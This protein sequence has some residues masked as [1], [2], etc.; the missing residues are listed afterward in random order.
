RRVTIVTCPALRPL[1]LRLFL[2]SRH[3]AASRRTPISGRSGCGRAAVARPARSDTPPSGP[4]LSWRHLLM[5][6]LVLLVV[7]ALAPSQASFGLAR[8]QAPSATPAGDFIQTTVTIRG[9]LRMTYS[10]PGPAFHITV[11]GKTYHLRLEDR[12]M[13][14]QA[15]QLDGETVVVTGTL[16]EQVVHVTTLVAVLP[17]YVHLTRVV[18]IK[19]RLVENVLVPP[20]HEPA[21]IVW[22]MSAAGQTYE[23]DLGSGELLE[24]A[25]ACRGR[26]VVLTGTVEAEPLSLVVPEILE[27]MPP[28]GMPFAPWGRVVAVTSLAV[29]TAATPEYVQE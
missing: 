2:W 1:V 3:A 22:E 19:G 13:L 21:R 18:K 7:A 4:L 28:R 17:D 12:A 29:E 16:A 20:K 6:K 10:R 8:A 5:R 11:E 15:A 9:T 23:V 14:R 26:T 24:L 25:R 27:R